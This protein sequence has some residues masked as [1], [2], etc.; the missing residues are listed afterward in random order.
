MAI[1]SVTF[2][3]LFAAAVF[4]GGD[5]QCA[6]DYRILQ[7]LFDDVN[8]DLEAKKNSCLQQFAELYNKAR[9]DSKS[10]LDF[11]LIMLPASF[12]CQEEIQKIYDNFVDKMLEREMNVHTPE[13]CKLGQRAH[14]LRDRAD[15]FF[16]KTIEEYNKAVN[17]LLTLY[18]LNTK[19]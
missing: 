3:L 17:E 7:S 10:I 5:D 2:V 19:L 16:T 1:I 14:E 15:E 13:S 11:H 9:A 8:T 18:A 12:K 4:A 6:S